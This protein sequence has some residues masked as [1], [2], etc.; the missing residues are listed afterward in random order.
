[1]HVNQY[2]LVAL[3]ITLIIAFLGLVVYIRYNFKWLNRAR[4]RS[5]KIIKLE[6]INA[7]NSTNDPTLVT[8]SKYLFDRLDK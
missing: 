8:V 5:E 6:I 3:L 7:L 2:I 4:Y 1:M